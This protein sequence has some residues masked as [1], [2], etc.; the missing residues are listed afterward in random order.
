M[1]EF[2]IG[3]LPKAPAS[4]ARFIKTIVAGLAV[5]SAVI[6]L[7]LVL[8]QMPFAQSFFVVWEICGISKV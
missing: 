4:T 3:Y 5:L 6:G 1:S 2:Y 8:S 7:L